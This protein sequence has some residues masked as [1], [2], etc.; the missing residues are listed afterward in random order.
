MAPV[1]GM[2]REGVVPLTL[3]QAGVAELPERGESCAEY[4]FIQ[5]FNLFADL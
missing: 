4:I 1:L 5:K 2:C 3:V